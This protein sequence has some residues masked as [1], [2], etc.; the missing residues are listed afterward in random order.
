MTIGPEPIT[1]IE[2]RSSRRGTAPPLSDGGTRC[3]KVEKHVV[4][5][6][7]FDASISSANSPN[8]YLASC[9]P[10]P[11]SGWYWTEKAGRSRQEM[12]SITPSFKLTWVTSALSTLP[13]D[14]A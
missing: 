3:G 5:P 9:G 10:G 6:P 2:E 4:V 13:G 11:A 14:T 7:H 12:P 8:R 1:R